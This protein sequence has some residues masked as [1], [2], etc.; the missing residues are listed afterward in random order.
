MIMAYILGL[1]NHAQDQ[2]SIRFN[3]TAEADLRELARLMMGEKGQDWF[4][5]PKALVR[6]P[7]HARLVHFNGQDIIFV[8]VTQSSGPLATTVIPNYFAGESSFGGRDCEPSY[9]DIV[10]ELNESKNDVL[11]ITGRLTAALT[12]VSEL[13]AANTGLAKDLI[14]R[15]KECSE[16]MLHVQ[17][18]ENEQA[19]SEVIRALSTLKKFLSEPS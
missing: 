17:E 12:R 8:C 10:A 5:A 2:L 13:E 9:V 18:L 7:G 1:T 19:P 6:E 3:I 11:V 15:N 4:D 14:A 16:L